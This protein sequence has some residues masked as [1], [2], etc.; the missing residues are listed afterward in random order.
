MS[1]ANDP[2]R[3]GETIRVQIGGHPLRGTVTERLA[4]RLD[5]LEPVVQRLLANEAKL[6]ADALTTEQRIAL[7]VG[8]DLALR[9]DLEQLDREVD[10][11]EC[12][13]P[14]SRGLMGRIGWL[15]TGR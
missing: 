10:L 3:V 4:A 13:R 7:L 1:Y 8:Q 12:A 11:R 9:A 5:A 6:I 15:L 14:W 2:N